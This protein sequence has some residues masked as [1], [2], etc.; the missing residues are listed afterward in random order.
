MRQ[1]EKEG[2]PQMILECTD[3]FGMAEHKKTRVSRTLGP[4]HVFI[5]TAEKGDF[6]RFMKNVG[7]GGGHSLYVTNFKVVTLS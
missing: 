1:K 7:G 2:G 6:I 5:R 4:N 3:I